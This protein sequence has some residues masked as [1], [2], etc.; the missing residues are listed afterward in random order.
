MR[1]VLPGSAYSGRSSATMVAVLA[2]CLVCFAIPETVCAQHWTPPSDTGY[3][4]T[5]YGYIFNVPGL[6]AGDEIAAFNAATNEI[7]GWITIDLD[8]G[9]FSYSM[10]MWGQ[11][12]DPFEVYFLIWDGTQELAV[13]PNFTTHPLEGGGGSGPTRHD[14]N[15]GVPEPATLLSPS[16]A[17]WPAS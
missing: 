4:E 7:V 5:V 3:W 2:A 9:E 11:N 16:P 13:G 15:S 8:G 6:H 12:E 1:G 10:V 14:L 17:V